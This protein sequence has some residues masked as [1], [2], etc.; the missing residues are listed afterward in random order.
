MS[1]KHR[2]LVGLSLSMGAMA[3]FFA[4]LLSVNLRDQLV[5]DTEHKASLVLS[6]AEAIQTYVRKTLRPAM[7]DLLHTDDFLVE[8]MS[9]SYVTRRIMGSL[10]LQ[11]DQIRYR[12]VAVGARNPASEADALERA[13]MERFAA[14]PGL[15]RIEEITQ[16]NGEEVFIAARPVRLD[17]SCLRCHGDPADAPKALVERYGAE[18]GFWRHPDELVGLDVVIAPVAGA[19]TQIKGKTI[20]FLAMFAVGLITLYLTVQLF[21][22]RLVVANLRRVTGVLRHYFP[23]EA[24]EAPDAPSPTGDEIEQIYAGIEALAARLKEA[25]E[26]IEDHAHHL[27]Q[28]VAARTQELSRE[29]QERRADVALF[30]DLL[31]LINL[32]HSNTELLRAALPRLAERFGASWAFYQCEAS[33]GAVIW[34]EDAPVPPPPANWRA[35]LAAG[36]LVLAERE[37]LI[38]VRTTDMSRGLLRLHFPEHGPHPAAHA[39]HLYRAVGQQLGLALENLDAIHS[40]MAHNSL[41]ASICNGISDP[42]ALVDASG[43]IILANEPARQLA[44]ALTDQSAAP[45]APARL[46][47]APGLAAEASP[48]PS[49][50]A[51][52]TVEL[53][54]GRSFAVARYPL[55]PSP[56]LPQRFVVYARENTA[57]RRMLDQ[58]RQT[59]KLVAVG[60]LAAGLAHEINNPL[61]VITCYT[62]LVRQ[63]LTDPQ[64]LEDLA[65]IERHA[66]QAKKVLR[67]LLDFARPRPA[68]PGPCDIKALLAAL[69]RIFQVQAQ[70]RRATLR[71]ELPPEPLTAHADPGALEQVLSNLLLNALDAVAPGTGRITL[72]AA[73]APD[74]RHIQVTVADNGP[75]IAE[76]I[77]PHIFDPFV[78]TKEVG[79]GTGLGLAVAFGLVRDMGGTITAANHDGAVFTI[80][81][82]VAAPA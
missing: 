72:A 56:G 31:H 12:R 60:K 63:R 64:A 58:L 24:G 29:A 51:L 38:P 47:D 42:L 71:L 79:R 19:L 3:V 53:D 74:G 75:G 41:L 32:S 21:F 6:Q 35:L 59:E 61:G 17:P 4:V 39:Q 33:A 25:R 68:Q 46:L 34:P 20:G 43:G 10:S 18:R 15:G 27:E 69:A 50:P 44:R 52:A 80:T 9:A 49:E 28:A 66:V 2:F 55:A 7:Y 1:L 45:G 57:E 30:V 5:T 54:D 36:E 26:D 62:E 23:Q 37:V 81:L 67:D 76:A 8:A 40:L 82:P 65:V 78:T 16:W 48:D 14:N 70:A 73:P 22:D 13:L 77:L 11:D